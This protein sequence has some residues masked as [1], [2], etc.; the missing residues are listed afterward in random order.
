[1]KILDNT[2]STYAFFAKKVLLVEGETDRYFFK[3]LNEEI[4]PELNQ[5]ITVLDI[6]GKPN[7]EVWKDF[8][9]RLF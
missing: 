4:K 7:Y 3:A 8:M 1:V 6:I 9:E 5:K 2:R